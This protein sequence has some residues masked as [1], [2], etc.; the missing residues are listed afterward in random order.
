MPVGGS[1]TIGLIAYTSIKMIGYTLAGKKL[2]QWYKVAKPRPFVFG[3]ARTVLGLAV[4]IS[5]IFLFDK[6]F[7][8]MDNRFL[9]FL[10]PVR[11]F[12]WLFFFFFFF[13]K[14]IIFFIDKF[15]FPFD[16]RFLFFF[17]PVRFFEWHL[18][19]YLFYEKHTYLFKR[20]SGYS[21]LG[22][23]WSFILDIPAIATIFIIPGGVWVC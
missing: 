23:L 12:E 6:L 18:I 5:V 16:N 15:F 11:F 14:H 19:I 10:I 13:K 22:I 3:I 1:P 4:G 2:N 20:I 17:I 9:F 8:T 7:S 21:L